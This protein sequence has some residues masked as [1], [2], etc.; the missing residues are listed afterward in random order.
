LP[1][2]V[3]QWDYR[4]QT[5]YT[6]SNGQVQ[7]GAPTTGHPTIVPQGTSYLTAPLALQNYEATVIDN[8]YRRLG[9]VRQSL[10]NPP[11]SSGQTEEVFA[12]TIDSRSVYHSNLS[13]QDYGYDFN[14]SIVAV[15]FGGNWLRRKR[16][17]DD[18]RLGAAV[19]LGHTSVNPQSSP[20]EASSTSFDAYNLAFTQTWQNHKG[21]YV[22]SV[23]SVGRYIGT[24]SSSQRGNVGQIATGFD[25]SMEAGRSILLANGMEIEPHAQLL[26]QLLRFGSAQGSDGVSVNTGDMLAFTGLLGARLSMP[27]AWAGS[28]K[29]YSRID[30]Q[31]T[32]MNSP[33]VTL[34]GQAF[35]VA[36]PGS[37]V[38][39]GLG[40]TGIVTKR[41]VAYGELAGKLRL[42]HGFDSIGATLGLRYTF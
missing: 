9:D 40:A 1:N 18:L 2:G 34:S 39:F 21:W 7:P 28:W 41:L 31:H 26:T 42:N 35:Q 5:S 19:T 29:P 37:S 6:D 15:Q 27:V 23:V 10:T 8:L 12:R 4:L 11:G 30:F 14:Q 16:E 36:S 25:V 32:W 20:V 22:D 3:A 38:Q 17:D 33:N 24:V 13:F